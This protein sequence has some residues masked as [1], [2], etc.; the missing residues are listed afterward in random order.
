MSKQLFK[1]EIVVCIALIILVIITWF[2]FASLFNEY[3]TAKAAIEFIKR[4][5]A[6]GESPQFIL[7]IAGSGLD[8]PL[9][10]IIRWREFQASIGIATLLIL[11][12]TWLTLRLWKSGFTRQRQQSEI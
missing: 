4:H 6:L 2:A 1:A 9:D 10:V 11:G 7:D 3:V 5:R 8:Q 12:I